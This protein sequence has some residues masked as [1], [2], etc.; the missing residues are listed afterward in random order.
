MN[1]LMISSRKTRPARPANVFTMALITSTLLVM[2]LAPMPKQMPATRK[3]IV[4]MK[5]RLSIS[6][7]S[8]KMAPVSGLRSGASGSTVHSTTTASAPSRPKRGVPEALA[9][10]P[11]ARSSSTR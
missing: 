9:L 11:R 5:M 8:S 3:S 2:V 6:G 1:W 7:E 10:R 4:M